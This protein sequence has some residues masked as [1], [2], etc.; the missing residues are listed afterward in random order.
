MS[1]IWLSA[2]TAAKDAKGDIT[3][4]IP[5]LSCSSDVFCGKDVLKV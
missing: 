1:L 2:V 3:M 5:E 4:C